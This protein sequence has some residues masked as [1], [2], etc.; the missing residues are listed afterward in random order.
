M[1]CVLVVAAISHLV[2][3]KSSTKGYLF[4]GPV[5]RLPWPI[6]LLMR[7]SSDNLVNLVKI[8]YHPDLYI[9]GT[10][11]FFYEKSNSFEKPNSHALTGARNDK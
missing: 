1:F 11:K 10:K 6:K 2:L 7:Y 3:R 9:N 8:L 5:N 4:H